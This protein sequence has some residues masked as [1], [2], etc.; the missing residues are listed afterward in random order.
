MP[1]RTPFRSRRSLGLALTG[2]LVAAAGCSHSEGPDAHGPPESQAAVRLALTFT[3]FAREVRFE[4]QGH[5]ARYAV[6]DADRVPTIL[7]IADDEQTP[8]DSC[9][10]VDSAEE[11]DRAL[12]SV[13]PTAEVQL[14][15]AGR[16]TV[17]GPVDDI[18][19]VAKHYPELTPY[20][21]GVV[22]GSEEALPLTFEPGA[23]YEVVGAGGEEIGPFEAQVQ[24]PRA[25][26][27]L[28]VPIYR[29]GSDLDLRWSEA[30]EVSDPMLI[31]ISW[32]SR[33]GAREVRCRVR[34]DGSFIVAHELLAAM[35]PANRMALAEVSAV[36]TRR[37]PLAAPGASRGWL[38]LGLREVSPLSISTWPTF[39]GARNRRGSPLFPAEVNH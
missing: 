24:A 9:R 22:Y 7:G 35:P 39:T 33:E 34:D 29:R 8:L 32:S 18:A 21:A 16:V 17:K 1:P 36:R 26:P 11:L 14:L 10:V 20:V 25:F 38:L 31:T 2:L 27:S 23:V 15:D 19:L 28:D 13:D 30:G 12:T 5:F 4:G 6:I 37:V 3:R